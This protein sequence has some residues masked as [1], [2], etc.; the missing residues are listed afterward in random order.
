[1]PQSFTRRSAGMAEPDV[2]G[3]QRRFDVG[4]ESVRAHAKVITA[5]KAIPTTPRILL[6]FMVHS[7][8]NLSHGFIQKPRPYPIPQPLSDCWTAVGPERWGRHSN[9]RSSV[10]PAC[11]PRPRTAAVQ[12]AVHLVADPHPGVGMGA[13][14]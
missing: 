9:V 13:A 12:V 7:M 14:V 5:S 3:V 1:M 6:R 8:P 10:R 4:V 11:P 2:T